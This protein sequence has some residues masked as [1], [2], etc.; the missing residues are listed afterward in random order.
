MKIAKYILMGLALAAT[1]SSFAQNSFQER[2]EKANRHKTKSFTAEKIS[3]SDREAES[4]DI[5]NRPV[6]QDYSILEVHHNSRGIASLI[7]DKSGSL[8]KQKNPEQ[9][10]N[11][12]LQTVVSE[13]GIESIDEL[14]LHQNFEDEIGHNHYLYERQIE[15]IPVFGGEIILSISPNGEKET[16]GKFYATPD[17]KER[18]MVNEAK[19]KHLAEELTAHHIHATHDDWRWI[20]SAGQ[21]TEAK[22]VWY[23]NAKGNLQQAYVIDVF[24]NYLEWIRVIVQAETGEIIRSYEKTCSIDG[25]KTATATDLNNKS[26]SINTYQIGSNY[27]LIDATKSM[28]SSSRS[29][30]PNDPE[31]AIWTIDAKSTDGSRIDQ[32]RSTNNTWSDKSSVSAHF[33]ASA[34]FDYFKNTHGRNSINGSGGTIISVVNVTDENGGGLDN[35]Y[36]NGKAMFYGNGKVGFK[37]L[38]GSQDVAGHEITHGV[39]SSTANLEYFSQSGAINES[40]ADVF[41]AMMDKEDWQMGEDVVRTNVFTSGA[42][43]DLSDPHNGGTNRNHNGY[44]PMKM[45]EYYAG[46]DDNQGV[47]INSGIP[48]HAFYLIATDIGTS[49]AEKIYYRTLTRYLTSSSEFLDL[50]FAV[51]KAASD[52][53]G[54]SSAEVSSVKSAFDKVEIFD[55]NA[56]SGNGGGGG[57]GDTTTLPTNTGTEYILS[58]DLDAGNS[59]TLYRSNTSGENFEALSTTRFNRKPSVLDDGSS[60]FF[61]SSS[62]EIRRIDLKG[63]ITESVVSPDVIWDNVAISKDGKR[64]AAVTEDV[65]SSI[66]VYDFTTKKWKIFQLYNPTFTEGVNAGGVLYADAIEFDNTGEFILYDARNLIKNQ[67][68]ADLD[69]WD[70]G[71]IKVWDNSIDDWGSGKVE[72]LYSQLAKDVDIGNPTYSR[73]SP[74]IIAFDYIDNFT[75]EF[76]VLAKNTATGKT[77]TILTNTRLSYPNYSTDDTKMLFDAQT[78]GGADVVAVTDLNSDKITGTGTPKALIG[79]AK[80]GVW[81]AEGSRKLLSANKDL[82]SFSFP[83]LEGSPTADISGTN[84]ILTVPFGTNVSNLIPTFSVSAFAEASVNGNDQISGVS[85]QNFSNDV[86]YKVTAQDKT[87]KTYRVKVQE[88]SNT[89]IDPSKS[90][91]PN[92]YPNPTT[93]I[94]HITGLF[95]GGE[96][97]VY[98]GLGQVMHNQSISKTD[99]VDLSSLTKGIYQVVIS[100][101]YSEVHRRIIKR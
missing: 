58:M 18:P 81:Y 53:H 57:S 44:Q 6:L 1:N 68:G 2:S 51:I 75:G 20:L 38:A 77:G 32:I 67:S 82:L 70:I 59:N 94:L 47:H 41:G 74:H 62:K 14:I 61:V 66:Y 43:R 49:K 91:R 12:F 8:S 35:A 29:S 9:D 95:E 101:N 65:D 76:A 45:S 56:G 36:W 11:Q 90:Y 17:K 5:L 48:N 79:L 84:A 73:N 37:P 86:L 88:E 93:G 83:S 78:Q 7:I 28:F 10:L 92:I 52:L 22:L 13:S 21:E 3:Y 98:N 99:K 19:A 30:L 34:A 89:G 100:T 97:T 27:Y 26:R 87:T 42:L 54:S 71:I 25:P 63:T 69:Y 24:P 55:P 85:A 23:P 60:C 16:R 15:G 72:K 64:L 46:E 31:G 40:M 33:N 39:V 80:W 96:I 50:R 4:W